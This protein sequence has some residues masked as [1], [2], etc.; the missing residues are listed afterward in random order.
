MRFR[1]H[2][3]RPPGLEDV[4]PTLWVDENGTLHIIIPSGRAALAVGA[5][6]ESVTD[7]TDTVLEAAREYLRRGFER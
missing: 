4:A 6:K 1:R 3:H 7:A 5:T 2:A